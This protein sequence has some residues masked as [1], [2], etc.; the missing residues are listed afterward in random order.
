MMSSVEFPHFLGTSGVGQVTLFSINYP[1]GSF[2]AASL[3]IFFIGGVIHP[4]V[5]L[6][7]ANTRLGLILGFYDRLLI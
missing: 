1:V 5:L 4:G 7:G 6:R 3:A 2:L